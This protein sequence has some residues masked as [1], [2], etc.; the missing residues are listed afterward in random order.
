LQFNQAIISPE[1]YS[2][3]KGFYSE[4]VKKQSEKIVLVKE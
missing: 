3:L 2:A 4:F 1:Y